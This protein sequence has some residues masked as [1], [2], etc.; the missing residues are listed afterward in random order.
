[1]KNRKNRFLLLAAMV[2]TLNINVFGNHTPKEDLVYLTGKYLHLSASQISNHALEAYNG[3]DLPKAHNGRTPDFLSH[4]T[5]HYRVTI[6]S[7]RTEKVPAKTTPQVGSNNGVPL[8]RNKM[9]G[10]GNELEIMG[11]IAVSPLG[12]KNNYR[13]QDGGNDIIFSR[14]LR[15]DKLVVTKY[16]GSERTITLEKVQTL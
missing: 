16:N 6:N 11:L 13:Q 7:F 12:H 5:R 9:F 1:M 10:E 14:D 8:T 3:Q 2:L 4:K 15:G